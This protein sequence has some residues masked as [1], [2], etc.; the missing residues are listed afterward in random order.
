MARGATRFLTAFQVHTTKWSE[1]TGEWEV[2]A[3][4]RAESV[5]GIQTSTVIK[6]HGFAFMDAGQADIQWVFSFQPAGPREFGGSSIAV[7][8]QSLRITKQE[9][10]VKGTRRPYFL[11]RFRCSTDIS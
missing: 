8:N 10:V 11:A 6:C 3:S 9:L 2:E 4:A 7:S 5:G 1:H